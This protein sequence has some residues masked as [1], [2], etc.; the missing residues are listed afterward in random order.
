MPYIPI[1][2]PTQFHLPHPQK[3]LYLTTISQTLLYHHQLIIRLHHKPSLP[4]SST[5]TSPPQTLRHPPPLLYLNHKAT[6]ST[7]LSPLVYLQTLT[8]PTNN[9]SLMSRIIT[10]IEFRFNVQYVVYL[11]QQQ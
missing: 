3:N 4:Q 11:I 8:I 10:Y 5:S 2:S 6:S 7:K 1:L 9:V